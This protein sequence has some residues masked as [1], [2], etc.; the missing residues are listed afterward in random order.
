MKLVHIMP[1]KCGEE[2]S[3]LAGVDAQM[4]TIETM[5][6]TMQEKTHTNNDHSVACNLM[7]CYHFTHNNL[8]KI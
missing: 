5:M 7:L 8:T 4:W 1:V 6:T 3:L 2:T